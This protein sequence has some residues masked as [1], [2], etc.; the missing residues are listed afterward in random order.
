MIIRMNKH[1][2]LKTFY[3]D[4]LVHTSINMPSEKKLTGREVE[5]MSEFWA[6]EGD[7]VKTFRFGPSAKRYIREKFGY[8]NYSNLDNILN[9]LVAK[10]YL[11]KENKNYFIRK[12]FDLPKD[13]TNVK[14]EY[15]YNVSKE[16]T[17]SGASE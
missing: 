10:G 4:F 3:V 6:L 17:D 12:S 7:L 15:N 9:N 16:G 14:I 13:F 5:I 2:N 8:K 11:G 1:V